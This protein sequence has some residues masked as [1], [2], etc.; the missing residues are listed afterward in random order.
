MNKRI[1]LKVV[2]S[3]AVDFSKLDLHMIPFDKAHEIEIVIDHPRGWMDTDCLHAMRAK[4]VE[5]VDIL[6]PF[7]DL[8]SVRVAFREKKLGLV[9]YDHDTALCEGVSFRGTDSHDDSEVYGWGLTLVYS[10]DYD[11]PVVECLMRP[12]FHLPI[13]KSFAIEPLSTRL[14]RDEDLHEEDEPFL[15]DGLYVSWLFGEIETQIERG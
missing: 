13:C 11:M 8:P 14:V 3:L 12:F 2:I 7:P 4:I 9:C 1:T 10:E 15:Y 5:F 6:K